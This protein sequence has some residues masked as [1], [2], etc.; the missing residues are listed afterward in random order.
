[1]F[2]LLGVEDLL[3]IATANKSFT[4]LEAGAEPENAASLRVLEKAG[5]QKGEYKKD[6]LVRATSEGGRKSDVQ[7]FHLDRPV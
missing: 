3:T 5:F 7:F 1:L 6:F 2:A 4:R